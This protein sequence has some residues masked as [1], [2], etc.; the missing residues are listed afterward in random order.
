MERQGGTKSK[1]R[2]SLGAFWGHVG[3][4]W[5]QV[6]EMLAYVEP[7][8]SHL[9]PMLRLVEAELGHVKAVFL[10]QVGALETRWNG[11]AATRLSCCV[12]LLWNGL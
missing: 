9:L 3:A 12:L 1:P 7:C 8:G 5:G 2:A 4:S 6:G 11:E 10:G